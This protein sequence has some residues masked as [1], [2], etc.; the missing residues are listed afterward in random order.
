MQLAFDSQVIS[1]RKILEIF[2]ILHNPTQLN[3]QGDD[4]GI[5]YRSEIF[6]HDTE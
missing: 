5:Q 1:F 4:V 6:T 3:R 2:F